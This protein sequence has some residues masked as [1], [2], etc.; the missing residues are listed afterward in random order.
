[1]IIIHFRFLN[2]LLFLRVWQFLIF[3]AIIHWDVVWIRRLQEM[4]L[5]KNLLPRI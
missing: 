2:L 3:L 4:L 1:L 5:L